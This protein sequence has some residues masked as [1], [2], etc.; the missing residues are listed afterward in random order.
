MNIVKVGAALAL[1]VLAP[2]GAYYAYNG[3]SFGGAGGAAGDAA[4]HGEVKTVALTITSANGPHRFTVEVAKTADEQERG[5][6]Y[7]TDIAKDGGM[8][9]APYP[10][11]GGPPRVANFWMKN[12]PSPLDILFIRADGTIATL[13]ENT[14]P[15][16]EAKIPSG[17]PI[18]AV[19][20]LLGGRAADLGISEGDKVTWPGHGG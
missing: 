1:C 3:G 14:V 17:E 8:L 7:R 4:A 13:A 15:F 10:P 2:A 12:T 18:A 19:L 5:L 6:M 20:E 16:S 9:F 11:E